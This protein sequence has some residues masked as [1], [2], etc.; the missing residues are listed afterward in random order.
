MEGRF[1]NGGARPI[2]C[3]PPSGGRFLLFSFVFLFF[4]ICCLLFLMFFVSF[5]LF[6][7]LLEL[8]GAAAEVGGKG[9]LKKCRVKKTLAVFFNSQGG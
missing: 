9:E 3:W 1:G 6:L 4:F 7:K 2:L 5:G 8:L